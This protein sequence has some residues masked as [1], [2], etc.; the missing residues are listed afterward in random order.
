MRM[1]SRTEQDHS[2]LWKAHLPA[3]LTYSSLLFLAGLIASVSLSGCARNSSAVAGTRDVRLTSDALP[4]HSIRFSPDGKWIA[5][6]ALTGPEKGIVGLY[7]VPRAGGAAK[8]ISPDSLGVYPI[9]WSGDGAGI[10]CRSRDGMRVHFV[11]MDGQVRDLGEIEALC[12][13]TDI[14]P[15]GKTQL[16]LRFNRDNRDIGVRRSG[17]EIE[18]VAKTP[19]WEEDATFGPGSGEITAVSYPSYLAPV[20]TI[21]VWSPKTSRFAPLPLPESQNYQPSWSADGRLMAYT[22]YQN[23]QTD[24]WAYDANTTQAAPVTEDPDDASSPGWSPDGEWLAY[25]RSTTSSHLFAGDPRSADR[26]QLTDGPARDYSPVVSPDGR[27]IAFLRRATAGGTAVQIGPKLCVM[28][29]SGGEALEL[30]LSGATL[31]TKG[32]DVFSWSHD[33]RSLA[34][35][36]TGSSSKMDIFRIDRDGENFA[37]VTVDPGDEIEPHW[38]PDGRYI[39]HTQVGGG[40]TQVAIVPAHGGL[41]R[42]MSEEGRPSES[43]AWTP[44]SDQLAYTTYREDGGFELWIA[45]IKS[46]ERRQRVLENKM[47]AWPLFWS[48]DGKEIIRVRHNGTKWDFSAFSPETGVETLIGNE[49]LLPSGKGMFVELTPEGQKFRDLFYPGGPV[50]ADGSATSDIY[51]VRAREVAKSRLLASRQKEV[52]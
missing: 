13:L 21:S 29:I 52:R 25:C 11:G 44:D 40:R 48:R 50:V 2:L 19:E 39:A 4:K 34:F 14:T 31:P 5:Y 15:D 45:P 51:L 1:S 35:N 33:S 42:L 38:S 6:G 22:V 43:G 7:V 17:G 23:G 18:Y 26:R 41:A 47:A 32:T 16:L 28:P 8:R 9:R 10:Y 20:S 30:D 46:P 24:V 37:R 36:A 3:I 27:W 12:R 49:A